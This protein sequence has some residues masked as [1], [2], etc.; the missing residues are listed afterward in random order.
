MTKLDFANN[1][2]LKQGIQSINVFI[3]LKTIIL[4]LIKLIVM[5]IMYL[6]EHHNISAPKCLIC[7]IRFV[8]M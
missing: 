6:M 2:I 3:P 4:A 1:Y 7:L 5:V 8:L